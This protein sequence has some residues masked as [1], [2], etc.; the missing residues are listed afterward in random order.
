[1]A[2]SAWCQGQHRGPCVT[3]HRENPAKISLLTPSEIVLTYNN[4][5]ISLQV[6]RLLVEGGAA[7][8][9]MDK[10]GWTALHL[11]VHRDYQTV[12][13]L[14]LDRGADVNAQLHEGGV[15][16]LYAT[17]GNTPL[18]DAVHADNLRMIKLLVSRGANMKAV[19]PNFRTPLQLAA[20][21]PY[22]SEARQFFEEYYLF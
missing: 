16:G 8:N 19:G 20:K 21:L 15:F 6:L 5:D 12:A 7:V 9:H 17:H 13:T 18:H 11:A 2:S 4:E 3:I 14:L 1:M 10:Y 22:D